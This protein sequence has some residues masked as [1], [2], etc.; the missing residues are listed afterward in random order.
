MKSLGGRHER[1]H[2]L[3]LHP[4]ERLILIAHEQ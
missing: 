1:T 3:E 2:D 4:Q